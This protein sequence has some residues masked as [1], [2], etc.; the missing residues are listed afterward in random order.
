M[1]SGMGEWAVGA[2]ARLLAGLSREKKK[3]SQLARKEKPAW[4]AY[5]Y[6]AVLPQESAKRD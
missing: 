5:V 3:I 4:G 6:G 1:E 2:S